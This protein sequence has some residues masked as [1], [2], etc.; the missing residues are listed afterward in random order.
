LIHHQQGINEELIKAETLV[1]EINQKTLMY[2]LL[3]FPIDFSKK[4]S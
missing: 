1:K 3:P 4:L 2:S